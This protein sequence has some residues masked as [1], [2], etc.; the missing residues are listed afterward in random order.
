MMVFVWMALST[1]LPYLA[2]VLPATHPGP[3]PR[4][5]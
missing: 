4:L 5:L 2:F 3:A 1:A